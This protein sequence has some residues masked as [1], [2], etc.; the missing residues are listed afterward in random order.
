MSNF[1]LQ[2]DIREL[3]GKMPINKKIELVR[4]LEK[5]TWAKRLDSVVNKIRSQIKS[6]PNQKEINRICK[7]V[8]KK[9]YAKYKGSN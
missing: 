5:E 6:V 7:K 3:I 1:M 9:V 2:M 8:R 4:E